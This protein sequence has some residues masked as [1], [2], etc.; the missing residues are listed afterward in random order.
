MYIMKIY[1]KRG[2]KGFTSLYDGTEVSKDNEILNCIGNIDE[3]NSEI[4]C[5][6]AHLKDNEIFSDMTA[7]LIAIQSQ[8]FD[9]GANVANPS[10]KKKIFFDK[11]GLY[12]KSMEEDIDRMTKELPRLVNFILPGGSIEMAVAHRIR[13]ICRRA[14]RSYTSVCVDSQQHDNCQVYLNRMSDYFFTIARY[15]GLKQKVEE[16]IYKSNIT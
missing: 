5:L 12:A 8:L 14:E 9:L 10:E 4:G 6:I 16:V 13:T 7:K 15:I 11:D 1:T 2:D 3:L